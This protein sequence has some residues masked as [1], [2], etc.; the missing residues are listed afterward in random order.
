MRDALCRRVHRLARNVAANEVTVV[1]YRGTGG[2]AAA[3]S[4]VTNGE[5][6]L[7]AGVQHRLRQFDRFLCRILGV[8]DEFK[9][10]HIRKR[11]VTDVAIV[12]VGGKSD[13]LV[14]SPKVVP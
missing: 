2:T 14:P 6:L 12:P 3:H 8:M 1:L 7:C 9:S 5:I 4:R 10:P 13:E 11:A